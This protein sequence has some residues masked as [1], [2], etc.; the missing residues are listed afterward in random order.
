MGTTIGGKDVATT[1]SGHVSPG[2]PATSMIPPTPPAGLVPAPFPYVASSSSATKTSDKLTVGG[3]PVLVEGSVMDVER[4]G[5]QPAAPPG[6]GDILTHAICGKAVTT[7]GSP[8]VTS[9]GK[10][11][12]VTGDSTVM[13]VPSPC[14]KVAQSNGRLIAA[15]DYN[16]SGADYAS[17]AAVVVTVGEPVAVVTGEVVDDMVDLALPGLIPV[18]WKRL[19]CSGRHKETTP[20]GRGGW[21]HALHQW[22]EVADERATMRNDD[23]RN[24]LFAVPTLR[25]PAFHRCKRLRLTL[26]RDGSHEVHSLD[27]RL[28]RRFAP[29]A[30]GDPRSVLH[31]IRDPRGN[32]VELV[33]YGGR[34]VGI[35]DTAGREL[36]LTH[37]DAGRIVRVEASAH[38]KAHQAVTYTYSDDG[39]MDRAADALGN[40]EL[41]AYDAWHRMTQKTLTNG[42]R[43]FYAFDPDT[44]R[45]CKTWGD[46]GLHT[47]GFDVDLVKRTATCHGNPEPRKYTW[48]EQGAVLREQTYDGRHVIEK[49][50]DADLH[51]TAERNAANETTLHVY[52]DLGNLVQTTDPAGNVTR[53]RFDQDVLMERIGPDGLSTKYEHDARGELFGVTYPTGERFTFQHDGKGRLT[54]I[55][56]PEGRLSA[57]DYD[58]AHNLVAEVDARGAIWR[59]A[60][61]PLG[62]PIAR[63]DP[64]GRVT[65]VTYD[66]FGRP[67][68]IIHADGTET[69]VE[70]DARGN[71]SKHVDPLDHVTTMEYAGTGS[72]VKQTTPDGQSWRFEYDDIERLTR[73]VNPMCEK[74]D[75]EYDRAGRVR[76]EITFDKRLLRY[77]YDLAGRLSRVEHPDETWR[78]FQYDPLGN[79]VRENSSHGAQVFD[80]DDLGRLQKATVIEHNGKTVVSFERDALGR[81][82]TEKQ[83]DR[84]LRN[85]YDARGRRTARTLPSGQVTRYHHEVMGA[86]IGVDHDGH[87][88]LFERDVLGRETRRHV[89]KGGVDLQSAYDSMDRL[90]EQRASA[91]SSAGAEL[92]DVMVQRSWKYDAAGQVKA[93]S[94]KR[95]GRTLYDYDDLGQ[96]IQARRGAH[97]DVF[98]YD[99]IGSLQGV[100]KKLDDRETCIPW[101]IATGNVLG[102]TKTAKFTNDK[103]NRRRT[104]KD[105]NTGEVTEYLWDCRDRLREVRL[106]D[107]RRVLYTYDAF[108]RRVRKE[109]VPQQTVA[110]LAS[111][112]VPEVHVVEMLW[113]GDALAAEYDSQHGARVHVHEPGTLVPMLQAE[114]GEVFAVVCDH[115]GMPK[116]LLGEDGKVAWAAAHTAWGRVVEEDGRPFGDGVA[117]RPVASPFRLLG[118][119]LDD[120]TGLCCTRFR[121]FEAETGRWLSPDPLGVDG[122]ANLLAF[123]GSPTIDVDPLGLECESAQARRDRIA[124]GGYF[125]RKDLRRKIHQAKWSDHG[126]KHMKAR[127]AEEAK[128]FSS[129]GKKQAQYLPEV[130]NKALEKTAIE[131]GIVTREGGNGFHAYY[132]SEGVVGYDRGMPTRWIRAEIS[133]DTYH[134]HPRA[135]DLVRRSVPG[136][137]E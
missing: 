70:Y 72:L 109:I 45:C 49:E 69:R 38:G 76:E 130:N 53:W 30:K 90:V 34:L 110:D 108:G 17:M 129:T 58:D 36:R 44:G 121:Y 105:R 95:W 4:P 77:Q 135:I 12:C 87:K 134:G 128:L 100:L 37:D 91:P 67:L 113:D 86:L 136:A 118:Q 102:G 14:G 31:E 68:T 22:I 1:G 48:N 56:G 133:N 59:Y 32:R 106:P 132:R 93:I 103:N 85:E 19:Y 98:D 29:L 18:E 2:P 60:Y 83:G 112:R 74:Y 92:R 96:L 62:R 5:N 39:D 116:E 127:S 47:V 40:A 115:L 8:R 84:T 65:R 26:L 35:V 137:E 78:A 119:Y 15:A 111:G 122:G 120:E 123:D 9:G 82:I 27:T 52:D 101:E 54:G 6:T 20:L 64:L 75:F 42:V 66:A 89:Y 104:K 61:D 79:L 55:F 33:Y 97:R 88:V 13:N 94:D 117:A 11:I 81:V 63:T 99:A 25:E 57:Y 7:S 23:G 73:I 28:T 80:R 16:A 50:Y 107:G 125:A 114:Q 43:F 131:R 41:Y 24:V 3:K 71:V 21:T 126:R 51:V 124:H 46:G 10:G